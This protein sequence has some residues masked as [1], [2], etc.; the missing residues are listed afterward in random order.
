MTQDLRR[1]FI[2]AIGGGIGAL[3]NLAVTYFFTEI[4]GLRY[5][6]SYV[7]GISVNIVFNFFYHRSITFGIKSELKNRLAK[8]IF[9]SV[10]IGLGIMALV[11]FFT[12]VLSVWYIF[13]GILAIGI[14]T[15][16]NYFVNKRWVF[17]EKD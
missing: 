13:S 11:Y 7:I 4:A 15:L 2:F 1:F 12:E 16:A 3:I 5:I 6:F 8:S 14:M 10:S 17:Y 9:T